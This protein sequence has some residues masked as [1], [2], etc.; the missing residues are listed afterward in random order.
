MGRS[1]DLWVQKVTGRRGNKIM[2]AEGNGNL[3]GISAVTQRCPKA[4]KEAPAPPKAE[5]KAKALKAKKAVLKDIHSHKK[6]KI[7]MSPTFRSP[8]TLR[9]RRQPKYP[10]KSAPRRNKLD[11]YAIIKLPLTTESAMKKIEDN[12]TL[13]FIVDV[14]ANKPDQISCEEAL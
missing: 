12:N 8:K 7:P 4:K 14:K 9:L 3:R 1:P 5:A 10:R 2:K 6:K 11:H 13:V